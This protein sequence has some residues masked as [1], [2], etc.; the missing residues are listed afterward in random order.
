MQFSN[1][2]QI[3]EYFKN[4][5]SLS[6]IERLNTIRELKVDGSLT[7][8]NNKISSDSICPLHKFGVYRPCSLEQCKFN[9]KSPQHKNCV[10]VCLDDN[11]NNRLTPDEIAS[12]FGVST[13]EINSQ[14][15]QII[16]KLQYSMVKETILNE[17]VVYFTY[18][19]WHCINCE[20]YIKDDLELS[21]DPSMVAA[22]TYGWCS[23][24]CKQ[25]KPAWMFALEYEFKCDFL[26]VIR[27]ASTIS[28][29]VNVK[30]GSTKNKYTR[31]DDLFNMDSG[32]ALR[33]I[34][35]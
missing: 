6:D 22:N 13:K 5:F 31:L 14:Y 17:R 16:K 2:V 27:V 25:A 28:S 20:L 9:F 21:T 24:D 33:Y 10:L 4:W 3:N 12:V 29:I 11:K 26:D 15:N 23:K 32:S 8:L 34:G 35:K 1:I 30:D 19:P 7:A 18:L